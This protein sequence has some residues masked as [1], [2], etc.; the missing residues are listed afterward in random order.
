MAVVTT[1]MTSVAGFRM[2]SFHLIAD[3]LQAQAAPFTTPNQGPNR[4]DRRPERPLLP[5]LLQRLSR[6]Y[7]HVKVEFEIGVGSKVVQMVEIHELDLAVGGVWVHCRDVGVLLIGIDGRHC[8]D[9]NERLLEQTDLA[10]V[11]SLWR[12]LPWAVP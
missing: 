10:C 9:R 7:R 5:K 2:N 6:H 8:V 12:S 11:T 3:P 4:R 1:P